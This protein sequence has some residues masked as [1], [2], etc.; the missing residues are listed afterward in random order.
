[1]MNN[2]RFVQYYNEINDKLFSYIP[3]ESKKEGLI[4]KAARYSIDSGGK[5]IRP[6][7]TLEF[8]RL[9]GGNIENAIEFACAVEYVHTYSLIHD[10][11]PC[12]DNDDMRRGRASCHICFGEADA[13]LTGDALLTLAFYL[14]SSDASYSML[15]AQQRLKAINSLAFYSGGSGMIGGQSV[16]LNSETKNLSVDELIHMDSL[17][18]G[19]LIKA[20][21][22]LGCIA[23]DANEKQQKAA[24]EFGENL[25]LA[26]QIVDDI[27]D[28]KDETSSG[29][30]SNKKA[31]YVSALGTEKAQEM[32]R[33]FTRIS[34]DALNVFGDEAE[35]LRELALN[36][37][38]R[39]I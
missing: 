11:L 22:V 34:L 15:T 33:M 3:K 2:P 38:D 7:L 13:L 10:D 23:A 12:M 24:E 18:T 8:C 14:L 28:A 30:I 29:D 20:A 26:F 32:A 5:R 31:T 36:L 4:W 16:D 21:C 35:F 1:M 27:I 17:K 39:K 37:L 9:C 19:A 6:I 25:G